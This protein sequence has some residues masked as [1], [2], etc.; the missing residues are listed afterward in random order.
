MTDLIFDTESQDISIV[1]GDIVI[2]DSLIQHQYDLLVSHKGD[3]LFNPKCGVGVETY[4]DDEK[5]TTDL[6][7]AIKIEFEKDGMKVNSISIQEQDFSYG[8]I[9]SETIK[10]EA[11][12]Q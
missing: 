1:G 4:L 6:F 5:T 11:T 10:I 7:R 3:W 8:I 12:Y 9:T 2:G